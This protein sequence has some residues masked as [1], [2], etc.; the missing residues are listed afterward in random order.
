MNNMD[1]AT[2]Y[3]NASESRLDLEPSSGLPGLEWGEGMVID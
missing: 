3:L 1:N 2:S